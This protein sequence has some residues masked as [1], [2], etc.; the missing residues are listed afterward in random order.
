MKRNVSIILGSAR[1]KHV[2][3]SVGHIIMFQIIPQTSAFLLH[4]D[5]KCI[6]IATKIVKV[7]KTAVPDFSGKTPK[8]DSTRI[9]IK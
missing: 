9:A 5:G 2:F 3:K 6:A 1:N 8:Y 7:A 4:Y